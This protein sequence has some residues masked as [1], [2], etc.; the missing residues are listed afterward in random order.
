[1]KHKIFLVFVSIFVLM[2]VGFT[3]E[4]RKAINF[5][6]YLTD[7]NGQP[8]FGTRSMSFV[9]YDSYTLGN[10]LGAEEARNVTVYNGNYATKL[11]V[12]DA[13]MAAIGASGTNQVWLEVNV[14]GSV[15]KPRVQLVSV[16][17]AGNVR[18]I[19]VDGVNQIMAATISA[20]GIV[21]NN[22]RIA[23]GVITNF[24][25]SGTIT[26]T[27]TISGGTISNVVL[28]SPTVN[29]GR[30]LYLP[31][32]G[33]DGAGQIQCTGRILFANGN[34]AVSGINL[35]NLLVSDSWGDVSSVPANGIYSKGNIQ[36]AGYVYNAV[37][38]DLAEVRALAKGVKKVPGKVY[39]MTKDGLK[40]ASK[41]CEIGTAGVCSD[42]YGFLLG[43][44]DVKD[45]QKA[46]IAISGWVLAY[47]DKDYPIGT[48]LTS[49]PDGVLT[50]MTKKE[51][52][53]Y[54]E[55][56]IGVLDTKPEKYNN[57]KLDGRYWVKV[58]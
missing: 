53:D 24:T 5:Q 38:N 26:N 10:V 54:P 52:R 57:V 51:K 44:K 43:G 47:V 41:R 16:P 32:S 48:A 13:T 36:T 56:L 9:Y 7:K 35:N 21:T 30:T 27:G 46:H 17:L 15:M 29:V 1:M 2:S 23:G 4:S 25:N 6:G 33:Y 39:V 20:N 22:G 31:A 49:G 55:R 19:R 45:A 18:G 14:N 34:S 3:A 42:T 12:D 11:D 28:S 37:W 58:K 50:A 40:L 8:V